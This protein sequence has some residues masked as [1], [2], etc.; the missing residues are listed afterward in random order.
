MKDK[1]GRGKGKITSPEENKLILSLFSN[2][3]Y[4][5]LTRAKYI[6]SKNGI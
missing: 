4:M 3:E 1:D 2:D 6:L 5:S